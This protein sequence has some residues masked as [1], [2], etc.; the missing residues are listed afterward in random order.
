MIGRTTTTTPL[1]THTPHNTCIQKSMM[2]TMRMNELL[3]T[4]PSLMRKIHFY[5]ITPGKE[6]TI[7][8]HNWLTIDRYSTSSEKPE[9]S[10]DRHRQLLIDRRRN[11]L[12]EGFTYEELLNMQRCDETDQHRSETAWGR[13]RYKHPIDRAHRP[14][15]DINPSTSIDIR[16]KPKTTVSER[17]KF[18][19]EYLTP[20]EFGIFRD[21]DGHARAIDGHILNVSRKDIADI[22]QTANGAENLS[23]HPTRQSIDVDVPTSVDRQ[24]EFCRRAFDSH[25]TRKFYWEEKDQYGVYIDE[26]GYARDLAGNTIRLHNMERASRDE[27]SYICLPEH[28]NLFTHTKLVPEIYT[29]D[30]INK[31]FYGVCGEQ[32]KNKEAFQIKLDGVHYPLNDSISWLTTCMEEMKQ[33][34]ARIQH[35]TDV[36]RSSSIDRYQQTSIDVREEIDQLVEGIYR[37]LE[38]TKERLHGRCD[39]IYFTMDLNISALTSKI[40]AIQGELVEI[41]RYIARRPEASS[42]IDKHNNKSTD[43]HHRTSVDDATNRGRL[44]PKMTSDMSDTHYHGEE[45]SADTYA[46]LR[47]HQFNLES[48]EERLQMMENTTATM[49]EK[50]RRGDEAMRYFSGP[51]TCLKVLASCDLDL[52]GFVVFYRMMLVKGERSSLVFGDWT[53]QEMIVQVGVDRVNLPIEVHRLAL[54]SL[55][56]PI[57]HLFNLVL[58]SR[59]WWLLVVGVSITPVVAAVVVA[60]GSPLSSRIRIKVAT[61]SRSSVSIDVRTEGSSDGRCRSTEDECIRSTVVSECLSTNQCCC[62]SMRSVFPCGLNVPNLQDLLR[63]AVEFPCCF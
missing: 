10:I 45:I 32:E 62:W 5:I 43:I 34:I 3:S 31:M 4:K 63:I 57:K 56:N 6:C 61:M 24:P 25:G 42:S 50:W 11:E 17:D 26:Q 33:D 8:R 30:E 22:L 51:D 37:T 23:R 59:W 60:V 55:K 53:M 28:A 27:P 48:L 16:S 19:N 47:R 9:T 46:T 13:T 2:K 39:D 38:T 29:K 1:L 18:N 40:E 14:S 52:Q 12:H 44:V 15:I 35:A 7:D 41:Q 54:L 21:P 36:V 20:D 58:L 49:K